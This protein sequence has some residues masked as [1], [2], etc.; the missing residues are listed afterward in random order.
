MTMHQYGFD[1]AGKAFKRSIGPSILV[2]FL[3][4]I[5]IFFGMFLLGQFTA[6]MEDENGKAKRC[7]SVHEA[8]FNH[9]RSNTTNNIGRVIG[10]IMIYC[11][12]GSMV[13]MAMLNTAHYIELPVR[14]IQYVTEDTQ[15]QHSKEFHSDY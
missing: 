2:T 14:K 4:M 10:A 15:Q 11:G 12:I 3:S 8:G 1:K 9:S 5:S 13:L 7:Y 6:S